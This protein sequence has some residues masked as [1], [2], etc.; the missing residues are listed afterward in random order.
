MIHFTFSHITFLYLRFFSKICY[1]ASLSG[2]EHLVTG[3]QASVQCSM[4]AQGARLAV[5]L[6]Q[7]DLDNLKPS[8]SSDK[9]WMGRYSFLYCHIKLARGKSDVSITMTINKHYHN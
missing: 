2:K 3:I 6:T 5:T 1:T 8:S 9:Y 4:M 7:G